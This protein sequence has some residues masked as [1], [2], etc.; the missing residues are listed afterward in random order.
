[1][2]KAALPR[3]ASSYWWRVPLSALS[4]LV[5]VALRGDAQLVRDWHSVKTPHFEIISRHDPAKL[6]PL[7]SD[8][9][10]A[11]SVFEANLGFKSRI[12]R[13]VL[14]LIPDSPL[15][16]EQMS[17]SKFAAGYY[18]GAPWRDLIVLRDLQDAR[19]GLLHEFAHLV[20]H[21]EGGR[22]PAWYK[23][24]TAEF[25]AEMRRTDKG[26]EVGR[27]DGRRISALSAGAWIPISY[28]A[29]LETPSLLNSADAVHRFYAQSWLYVHML[30]LS[31]SYRSDVQRFRILIAE[32]VPTEEALRRVFGKSLSQFDEDARHWYKQ[33]Q[34]PVDYHRSPTEPDARATVHSIGELEVELAKATVSGADHRNGRARSAYRRL[35]QIAGDQCQHQAAL[36]DL[37]YASHLFTQAS[38]HYQK[39]IK[40]G[41]DPSGLAKGLESV[42]AYRGDVSVGELESVVA[43]TGGVRSRYLLGIARYFAGDYEGAVNALAGASG[44]PHDDEFRAARARALALAKLGRY[45]DARAEAEKLLSLARDGYQRQSADLTIQDVERA[46]RQ[47]ETPPVPAHEAFL[48][49][50]SRVDGEVIR[51]DCMG[52][53]AR[54]WVRAGSETRKLIVADPSEVI[55]GGATATKLEFNCGPQKRPVTIGYTEQVDPATDTVGRIKYMQF[56]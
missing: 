15:E 16:Y 1:M 50:L 8:L 34:Y 36:G 40:C 33:K 24:G 53:R 45:S 19:H 38:L 55:T 54:F 35:A 44:L 14:I 52:E 5:V 51:V 27:P 6:G 32:G 47:A 20:L 22:W 41:V 56:R 25:F 21:H 42:L 49:R 48:R 17:P 26:V 23:E 43:L 7:L 12:D 13:G 11:R 37:A 3:V 10:W 46:R 9:E 30:H 18:R 31:P 2:Q 28:L 39:A 4:C 29:S